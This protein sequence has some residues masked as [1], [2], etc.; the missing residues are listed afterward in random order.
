VFTVKVGIIS[1]GMGVNEVYIPSGVVF[2]HKSTKLFGLHTPNPSQ[3]PL[4]LE[5]E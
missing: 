3:E 5:I 1:W 2:Y 4:T